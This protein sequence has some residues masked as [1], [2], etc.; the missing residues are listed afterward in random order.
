M[1]GLKSLAWPA[2]P[3]AQ[4]VVLIILLCGVVATTVVLRAQGVLFGE[5]GLLGGFRGAL[6]Q[7]A[8]V[9]G[10]AQQSG[11]K[12]PSRLGRRLH[13]VAD[14][15][16]RPFEANDAASQLDRSELASAVQWARF[17]AGICVFIGLIGTLF[18][19]GM[20]ISTVAQGSTDIKALGSELSSA[21]KATRT[22]FACT[23][24]GV[25]AS[26]L[27]GMVVT[28]YQQGAERYVAACEDLFC[29]RVIPQ[30]ARGAARPADP[31]QTLHV[32]ADR[33]YA[34]LSPFTE[35]LR[36]GG[37]A[38]QTAAGTLQ[39]TVPSLTGFKDSLEG[40][41]GALG[42]DL[43]GIARNQADSRQQ[44]LDLAARLEALAQQMEASYPILAGFEHRISGSIDALGKEFSQLSQSLGGALSE[45]IQQ[46]KSVVAQIE[47]AVH[48]MHGALTEHPMAQEA[49]R[50]V[51]RLEA[52]GEQ[53]KLNVHGVT[54]ATDEMKTTLAHLAQR[55]DALNA[56]LQTEG[57]AR[58]EDTEAL[59]STLGQLGGLV[60]QVEEAIQDTAG[61]R[62]GTQAATREATEEVQKLKQEGEQAVEAL[63]QAASALQQAA[64]TLPAAK[65]EM[66]QQITSLTQAIQQLRQA[67]QQTGRQPG[68]KR[69]WR[70]G[71]D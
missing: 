69:W 19:L 39:G 31:A 21:L 11:A 15:L 8:E 59:R 12:L 38:I 1:E 40:I 43:T 52:L 42:S 18:G 70:R 64:A 33:L 30:L 3:V 17:L 47:E 25:L 54:G 46:Q 4:G 56:H 10:A 50:T 36:E 20:A 49:A 58:R 37:T 57:T 29:T 28:W 13:L 53:L 2:E 7:G 67:T 65:T 6:E 44:V 71:E 68:K 51:Q 35:A 63:R 45:H 62:Q 41:V 48:T 55:F 27:L 22:G 32:A 34:A 23:F 61:V 60:H 26:V 9:Q 5:R 16:A 14:N 24:W 66:A